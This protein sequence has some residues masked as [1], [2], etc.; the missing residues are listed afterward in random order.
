MDRYEAKIKVTG[1]RSKAKGYD[2]PTCGVRMR[3]I[4]TSDVAQMVIVK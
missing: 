2:M 1:Q 3:K 4:D